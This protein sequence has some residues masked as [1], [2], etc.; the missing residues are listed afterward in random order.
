MDGVRLVIDASSIT[1]P[2]AAGAAPATV[3]P[4]SAAYA[5]RPTQVVASERA[6]PGQ[7]AQ[8]KRDAQVV[9]VGP[10]GSRADCGEAVSAGF[11]TAP[12]GASTRSAPG[13]R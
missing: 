10:D 11:P 8:W 4:V 7:P 6:R 13:G 5:I 12:G 3:S 1:A 9:V 2:P